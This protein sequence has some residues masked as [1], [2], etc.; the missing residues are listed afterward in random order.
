MPVLENAHALVVGIANYQNVSGLSASVLR[1]SMDVY[2][3]LIDPEACAYPRQNVTLLQDEKAT[4]AAL[5]G[6]LASLAEKTDGDSIVTIYLSSHGGRIAEG[7]HRGEYI[8]PVDVRVSPGDPSPLASTAISGDEFSA[9]LAAIPARKV[10]VLLDCC[11]AGGIGETK[12]LAP[13]TGLKKG[14]SQEMYD[15]LGAGSGR[16]ILA[17]ARPEEESYILAG[18]ANSLFTKHLLDG[19][20]GGVAGEDEFVRIFRL[21]EYVQP[22]VTAQHSRQ[23]PRFKSNLEENFPIAFYKGGQKKQIA[24]APAATDEEFAYDVY[25]SYTDKEPDS[26][27]VWEKFVPQLEDAG[28]PPER[29]AVVGEVERP[30]V[31]LLLEAERAL[32]HSKRV[33]LAMSDGYF[34][35]M[36]A[37]FDIALTQ[38]E[39][40][41]ANTFRLLPVIIDPDMDRSLIPPRLDI[42]GPVDVTHPRMGERR[43]AK[44]AAEIKGPLPVGSFLQTCRLLSWVV[45]LLERHWFLALKFDQYFLMP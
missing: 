26:A 25:I 16:A 30:G 12:S 7:K 20:R 11:H 38:N 19:L 28:I 23:H 21:Y 22:K 3:T 17:S 33:V 5:R 13:S 43:L 41:K 2:K 32:L 9:A 14:F 37:K 15:R 36:R 45:L 27:W 34:A 1:D 24:P 40:V 42:Y 6:A 4:G 44:V 18:D 39:Q 31:A 8:A 35:D 10:L 29:I